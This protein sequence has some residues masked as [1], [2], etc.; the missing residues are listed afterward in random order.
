MLRDLDVHIGCHEC[1]HIPDDVCLTDSAV[2]LNA[3]LADVDNDDHDVKDRDG[4]EVKGDVV[5][6]VEVKF[7]MDV[8]D[9]ACMIDDVQLL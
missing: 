7:V 6:E 4:H 2:V 5:L 1:L 3:E 9:I 8:Q